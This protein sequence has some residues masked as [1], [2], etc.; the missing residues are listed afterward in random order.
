MTIYEVEVESWESFKV[1]VDADSEEEAENIVI[2]DWAEFASGAE[3]VSDG[4]SVLEVNIAKNIC[5]KCHSKLRRTNELE[6]KNPCSGK[7]RMV[8]VY[9]C[10]FCGYRKLGD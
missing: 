9:N 6:M 7:T 1:I 10:D 2:N 3:P 5:P 4:I 8:D